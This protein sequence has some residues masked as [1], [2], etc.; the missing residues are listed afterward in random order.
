MVY[1]DD[2][3]NRIIRLLDLEM[4]RLKGAFHRRS[5]VPPVPEAESSR[6]S[7]YSDALAS[8]IKVLDVAE[9]TVDGLPI[10][11]LKP[12]ISTIRTVLQSVEVRPLAIYI[13]DRSG[14]S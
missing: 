10:Q 4:R 9:K 11:G 13:L 3:L 8:A 7:T 2:I 5:P 14:F 1:I 6:T 12:V